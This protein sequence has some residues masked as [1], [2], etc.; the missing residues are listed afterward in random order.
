MLLC[1]YVER[2]NGPDFLK[3]ILFAVT[4]KFS[5][6]KCTKTH[7]QENLRGQQQNSKNASKHAVWYSKSKFGADL[8]NFCGD[9]CHSCPARL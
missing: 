1:A 6:Q 9:V 2:F 8:G 7:T 3:A 4:Y 5:T